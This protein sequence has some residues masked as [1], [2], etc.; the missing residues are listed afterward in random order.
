MLLH[1][2]KRLFLF[3]ARSYYGKPHKQPELNFLLP[4]FQYFFFQGLPMMNAEAKFKRN[5]HS[6]F[7]VKKA[8]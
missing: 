7:S 8:D 2:F 1:L 5:T 6:F 4:F 3:N